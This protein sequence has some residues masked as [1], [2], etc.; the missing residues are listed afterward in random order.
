MR[1]TSFILSY[2]LCDHYGSSHRT[3]TSSS[4]N[5][6]CNRHLLALLSGQPSTNGECVQVIDLIDH[7]THPSLCLWTLPAPCTEKHPSLLIKNGAAVML[8]EPQATHSLFY[9]RPRKTQN[10]ELKMCIYTYKLFMCTH[11]ENI[12]NIENTDTANLHTLKY[13]DIRSKCADTHLRKA[14]CCVCV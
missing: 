6:L 14:H 3:G 4:S 10:I 1:N 9:E 11:T 13:L 12:H 8:P 2:T 7:I 5:H